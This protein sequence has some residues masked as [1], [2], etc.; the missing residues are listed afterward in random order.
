MGDK[1]IPTMAWT[2]TQQESLDHKYRVG[3]LSKSLR[4]INAQRKEVAGYGRMAKP[5][6]LYFHANSKYAVYRYVYCVNYRVN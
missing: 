5:P 2:G 3:P 4:I 6:L 1:R